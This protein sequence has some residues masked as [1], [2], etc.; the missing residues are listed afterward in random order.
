MITNTS[1]TEWV[2]ARRA[3][4][5]TV[6]EPGLASCPV[7]DKL[8][9]ED[10]QPL[11]TIRSA[12]RLQQKSLTEIGSSQQ[13]LFEQ[14]KN[15]ISHTAWACV[16]YSLV[17][18]LGVLFIPFAFIAGTVGYFVSLKLPHLGGRRLAT[19]CVS[20]SF[21][22]LGIQILLWWLLYLV[23]HLSVPSNQ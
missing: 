3:C 21:L 9:S 20:L 17:P 19:I 14:N 23:P 1:E 10:Y 16:V 11:D 18:Y 22:I 13:N 6:T 12:Y 4:G 15:H 8:L 5:K 7:C 2:L